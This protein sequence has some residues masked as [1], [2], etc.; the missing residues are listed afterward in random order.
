MCFQSASG[1]LTYTLKQS[2]ICLFRNF[3]TSRYIRANKNKI[4]MLSK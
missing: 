1:G 4:L 3:D 2:N